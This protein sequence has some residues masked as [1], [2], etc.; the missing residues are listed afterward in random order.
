MGFVS[1]FTTEVTPDDLGRR[2]TLRIQLPDGRFR[3][4]VGVLESWQNRVIKVRRRDGSVIE[5]IA[6]DVVGSKIIPQKPPPR[7]GRSGTDAH[8]GTG[9]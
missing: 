7:R 5:V 6:D 2:A 9:E 8:D 4:I 1:R 3:D